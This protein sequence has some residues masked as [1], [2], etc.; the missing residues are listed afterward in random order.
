[1]NLPEFAAEKTKIRIQ[2]FKRPGNTLIP[3]IW[4]ATTKGLAAAEVVALVAALRP[5]EL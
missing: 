5:G 2:A 1:M 4:M 3:L